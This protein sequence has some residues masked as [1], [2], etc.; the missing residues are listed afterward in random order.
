MKASELILEL[1]KA[2]NEHGDMDILVRDCSDGFD[3]SGLC[4]APDPPTPGEKEEGVKGTIDI[5]VF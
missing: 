5:N 2:V 4:V 1:Q 3:W